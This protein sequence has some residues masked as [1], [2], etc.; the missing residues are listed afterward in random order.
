MT[1]FSTK[2]TNNIRTVTGTP[3]LKNDDVILECDT[4]LTPVI[5]NL[6]EI[7]A[8]QWNTIWKLYIVD[9]SN[10][11]SVNNITVNAPLGAKING[12]NSFSINSNGAS[13]VVTISSNSNFIGQYS[14]ISKVIISGHVIE[15]EGIVL[16]QKPI[17]DFQGLGV[18]ATD[19]TGKTIVT[20]EGSHAIQDEGVSLPKQPILDFQGLGVVVTDSPGKTIVTIGGG[21]LPTVWKDI[22]NLNYY[23]YPLANASGFMPQYN[24]QGNIISLRGVLFVPLDGNAGELAISTGNSYLFIPSAKTDTSVN[25]L[26]VITNA[27]GA[28]G[29]SERQGR[30]FTSDTANKRNFPIIDTPIQRDVFFDNVIATR[31]YSSGSG[32]KLSLYRSIVQLKI[33]STVTPLT[34]SLGS[35]AGALAIFSPLN[36][37]YAGFVA[38]T[39]AG[40]D[41]LAL[42][43]SVV[44]AGVAGND[45]ILAN[46]DA[47]FSIPSSAY[48][49]PFPVNAH[50]IT[51]LGG[52]YINLDGLTGFI[53]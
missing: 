21:S 41:P 50:D 12:V 53:N 26:S 9:K 39:P 46:D 37:E 38:A 19:A 10:N 18:T 35:G 51:S 4:T 11:A 33:C 30:F 49:S 16:P 7:P 32:G 24:I 8:N 43:I 27:N 23:N 5:I 15:D 22:Q 36:F 52:F 34:S 6:L 20:I 14:L 28:G 42:L 29:S 25:N 40:N 44:K 47:P 48:A 2:Y 3:I 31:R 45:Y 13:L 17:L 1:L